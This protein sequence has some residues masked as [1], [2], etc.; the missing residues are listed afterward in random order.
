MSKLTTSADKRLA[1]ISKVVLVRVEFSKKRLKTFLPRSNGTFLTSRSESLTATNCWAVSKMCRICSLDR[2]SK[3]NRWV[4]SPRSFNCSW[5]GV[6]VILGVYFNR[7]FCWVIFYCWSYLCYC[8]TC[9]LGTSLSLTFNFGHKFKTPALC[10]VQYQNLL[11][12]YLDLGALKGSVD[13]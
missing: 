8:F 6:F 13:G 4:N 3:V 10:L 5:L 2:P 11:I 9:R 12:C 1:A 7:F